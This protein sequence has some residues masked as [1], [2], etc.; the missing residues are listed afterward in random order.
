MD[1]DPVIA[2]RTPPSRAAFEEEGFVVVEE[3]LDRATCD[4]LNTRLEA[5]L[6][7]RARFGGGDG[8]SRRAASKG[9]DPYDPYGGGYDDQYGYSE[10]GGAGGGG[11]DVGGTSGGGGL[12]RTMSF[13]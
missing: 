6:R 13:M 8:S 3:L 7:G 12:V 2:P 1:A 9:S 4:E 5:V 11:G 10:R